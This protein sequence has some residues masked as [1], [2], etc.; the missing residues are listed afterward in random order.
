M[1]RDDG[2]ILVST[3][4]VLAILCLFAALVIDGGVLLSARTGAQRAADAAALAGAF[5]FVVDPASPQPQTAQQHALASAVS[6]SIVDQPIAPADVSV[7]VDVANRRVTVQLQHT[8]GNL[9]ARVVGNT[10]GQVA[11]QAVAEASTSATGSACTKPWFIPNTVLSTRGPCPACTAAETLVDSSG[12][13]TSF[14]RS[15]L[16]QRF[17]LKPGDPSNA[18]APGQFFAIAFGD[19][20]GGAAYREHIAVCLEGPVYCQE[21]YTA[22]PGN[23]TGPTVQGVRDLI[24]DSRD[25][26]VS[27]GRYQRGDGTVSDTSHQLIVAPIWN[28]CQMAGFCP[29][30]KL[31]DSG[32]N[33]QIGVKGFAMIFLEGTQG[34]DVLA[35]VI[36]VLPCRGSSGGPSPP[37]TGPYSIPVRLVRLP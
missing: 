31:P 9:F 11:V 3:A 33:V 5:T 32:R 25:S 8:R 36:S 20:R 22:E 28:E 13:V 2:Y 35:R 29:T 10:T 19:T 37:E 17:T 6:N 4:L 16:G 14:A 18:L 21:T 1:K 15:K 24:G 23:M 7:A 30:G 26:F 12:N 34:N 27:V